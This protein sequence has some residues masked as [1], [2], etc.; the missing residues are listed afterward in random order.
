[1]KQGSYQEKQQRLRDQ[2]NTVMMLWQKDNTDRDEVRK[3]LS[4]DGTRV[5]FIREGF[6][7][8]SI[9]FSDECLM[10]APPRFLMTLDA[11][12]EYE[13]EKETRESKAFGLRG[14]KTALY[15]YFKGELFS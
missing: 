6:E 10:L 15:A 14:M 3:T 12:S 7:I 1:M 11:I 5:T 13:E 9:F 2:F 4:D 8:R